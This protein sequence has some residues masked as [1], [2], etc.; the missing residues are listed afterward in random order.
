M[1]VGSSLNYILSILNSKLISFYSRKIV[2]NLGK[3]GMSLT[4]EKVS[5]F[6]I[7]KISQEEQ[8]PFEILV[9][10]ILYIKEKKLDFSLSKN[11]EEIIDKMVLDLYFKDLSKKHQIYALELLSEI[12]M[13][14]EEKTI[15]EKNITDLVM[16]LERMRKI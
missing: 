14:F 7:P 9:D 11:L 15:N 8:K 16:N 5:F 4:K 2:S 3:D 13:K 6:P 1:I 10:F 12:V